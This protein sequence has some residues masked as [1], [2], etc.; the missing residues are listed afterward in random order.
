MNFRLIFAALVFSGAAFFFIY[1]CSFGR[2]GE[3]VEAAFPAQSALVI[4]DSNSGRIYAW[5]PME[6]NEE[7]A[8]EFIHSV[9]QSPVTEFFKIENGTIYINAVRFSSFGAGME[10]DFHEGHIWSQEGDITLISGLSTSFRELNYIIGTISDHFLIVRGEAISLI[11]LL[12]LSSDE[13][14]RKNAH[15]TIFFSAY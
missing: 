7:F 13:T 10:S 5:W 15:I 8:I 1:A 11:Q 2:Y 14:T 12:N 4:M 3:A 6:E 9:S